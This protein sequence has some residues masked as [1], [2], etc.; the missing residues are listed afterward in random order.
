[1]YTTYIVFIKICLDDT[2][3]LLT[4][5]LVQQNFLITR[6]V[7]DEYNIGIMVYDT[8]LGSGSDLPSLDGLNRVDL[9]V[10]PG[11]FTCKT[12]I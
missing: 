12:R 10:K 11:K 6:H 8:T 1:M 2:A 3:A 4:T 9:H 5:S 7:T